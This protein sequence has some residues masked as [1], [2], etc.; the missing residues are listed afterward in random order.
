MGE[1]R[2]TPHDPGRRSV[3]NSC[4][5]ILKA[6]SPTAMSATGR[7]DVE[8]ITRDALGPTIR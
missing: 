8:E 1:A 5:A 7:S 6:L 3:E 2:K 4:A